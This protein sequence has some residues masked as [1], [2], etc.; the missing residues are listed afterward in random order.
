M[1][2]H[3]KKNSIML[4]SPSNE[5]PRKPHF[6]SKQKWGLVGYSFSYFGSETLIMCTC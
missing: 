1:P 3:E 5:H 4:T 2:I 6:I